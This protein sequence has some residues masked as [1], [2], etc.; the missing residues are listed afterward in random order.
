MEYF[1]S[2]VADSSSMGHSKHSYWLISIE[3]TGVKYYIFSQQRHIFVLFYLVL[4]MI[5]MW[6]AFSVAI[7]VAVAVYGPCYDGYEEGCNLAPS[8]ILMGI[9]ALVFGRSKSKQRHCGNAI[10]PLIN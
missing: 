8:G 6:V 7:Y 1:P 2:W 3:Y 4:D 5:K 10:L 9:L